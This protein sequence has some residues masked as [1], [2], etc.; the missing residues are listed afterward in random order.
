MC[1]TKPL[2]NKQCHLIASSQRKKYLQINA[3]LASGS[4]IEKNLE[5]L[6]MKA[7]ASFDGRMIKGTLSFIN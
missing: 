6:Q 2:P 7:I 3:F 1:L 4:R 5:T